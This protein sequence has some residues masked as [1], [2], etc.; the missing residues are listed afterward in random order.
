[1]IYTS[2][3]MSCVNMLAMLSFSCGMD[4]VM[5]VSKIIMETCSISFRW[6]TM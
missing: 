1:M 6:E 4:E 3:C 5:D 2:L